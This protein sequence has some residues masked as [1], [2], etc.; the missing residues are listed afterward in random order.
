MAVH[1]QSTAIY[2]C[3]INIVLSSE[4]ENMVSNAA[5]IKLKVEYLKVDQIGQFNWLILASEAY[6]VRFIVAI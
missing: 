1:E 5:N 2:H 3:F 6:R 4:S